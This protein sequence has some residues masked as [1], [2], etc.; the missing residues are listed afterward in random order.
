MC[1]SAETR[2]I[3]MCSETTR[4]QVLEEQKAQVAEDENRYMGW[5]QVMKGLVSLSKKFGLDSIG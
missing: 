1:K 2:E 5:D 4:T 3:L